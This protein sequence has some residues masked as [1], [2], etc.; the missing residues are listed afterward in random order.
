MDRTR[1]G[2][3][4]TIV[5][6]VYD[7]SAEAELW[8][9]AWRSV[10]AAFGGTSGT[11]S[12]F[13][14]GGGAPTHLSLPGFSA[15]AIRLYDDYYHRVDVW[16]AYAMRRTAPGAFLGEDFL[17]AG[18][19]AD[20]EMWTD[21]S[22]H[23]VNAFHVLG[24]TVKQERL[25]PWTAGIH[26][27][28][29][30]APFDE[31]DRRDLD[32]LLP[33][34]RR[35][36]RMHA[37]LAESRQSAA[38]GYAALDGIACGVL[39][40]TAEGEVVFANAAAEA[41]ASERDALILGGRMR[42]IEAARIAESRAL[43]DAIRD[44][45]LNGEGGA[46]RLER[47]GGRRPV[48]ALVARLP[49]RLAEAGASAGLALVLLHDLGA[50]VAPAQR[51]LRQLFGATV[52]EADLALALLAGHRLDEI[53]DRRG[54]LISTLRSQL[55]ALLARTGTKRQADLLRLLARLA[56]PHGEE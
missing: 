5:E 4:E 9:E 15:E 49:R 45:A 32:R 42:G 25:G 46:V 12:V 21:Y 37:L 55:S 30:A 6:A 52:A 26:R 18:D 20:S 1:E 54:T 28:K 43:R 29:G 34:L 50:G 8:P 39:I 31:D 22:R 27:P 51:A 2:L 7:A 24:A 33:H 23:H 3:F 14:A 44:A 41:L 11:L 38:I 47:G 13:P 17:S 19:Y 16:G 40:A 56:P 10:V 53:A 36:L 35:A 48:A